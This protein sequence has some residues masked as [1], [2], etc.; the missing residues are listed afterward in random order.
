[1]SNRPKIIADFVSTV[2][3]GILG[4]RISGKFYKKYPVSEN[5]FYN[6]TLLK[7]KHHYIGYAAAQTLVKIVIDETKNN[8]FKKNLIIDYSK[9]FL[10]KEENL[11]IEEHPDDIENI[12]WMAVAKFVRNKTKIK[13]D[14]RNSLNDENKEH[15]A[16][17][18]KDLYV[19]AISFMKN[20]PELMC[21]ITN[22]ICNIIIRVIIK[23]ENIEYNNS[24]DKNINI[25]SSNELI[26]QNVIY[27]M[28]SINTICYYENLKDSQFLELSELCYSNIKILCRWFNNQYLNSSLNRI[29]SDVEITNDNIKIYS[30]FDL[31]QIGWSIRDYVVEA[32]KLN[33]EVIDDLTPEHN[34]EVEQLTTMISKHPE[35]RRILLNENNEMIGYWSVEPLFDDIFEKAKS[36]ELFDNELTADKIVTLVPGIYNVYFSSICLKE[37]YRKKNAFKKLLFSLIK[38]LEELA[39]DGIFFN[40][41]CTLAYSDDGRS[42]SKTIGLRLY[43]KHIDHGE[44]YY[45]DIY[46]ILSQP[47][48]K[49]FKALRS[50]YNKL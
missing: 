25:I 40:E 6:Y 33:Y 49:D 14:Y 29:K 19:N 43:K 12:F 22:E 36:G 42:L 47:I 37:N 3:K 41:I 10:N 5:I 38:Y 13:T 20:K 31:I 11:Y 4:L 1:M 9:K 7:R 46:D 15:Y 50:L 34:G 17:K 16:K 28:K 32:T 23:I 24:L 8:K 39:L 48:C 21:I 30:I 27:S 35:N 45:G 18:I 2:L 44:I 26:P